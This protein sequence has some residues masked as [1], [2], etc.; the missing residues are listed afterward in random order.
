MGVPDFIFLFGFNI[1][2]FLGRDRCSA[3][4]GIGMPMEWATGS[5]PGCPVFRFWGDW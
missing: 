2:L 5:V 4:D 1:K 3:N